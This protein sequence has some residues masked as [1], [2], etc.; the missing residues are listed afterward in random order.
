VHAIIKSA[1]ARRWQVVQPFLIGFAVLVAACTPARQEA[2]IAAPPPPA[3]APVAP[4]LPVAKLNKVALLVP[5]TGPNAALGESIANAAAMAITDLGKP[6]VQ[7]ISF[8]TAGGAG[9]AAA[10][11]LA[12][13][14]G[15]ILGPLLSSEV[16]AV[17]AAVAGRPVP[18]LSFSNDAAAAGSDVFVLGF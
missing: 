4:A 17:Q 2:P 3:T 16:P 13:G 8:D 18:I 9:E 14:A 7:L 15:L 1:P 11:A 10:K 12:A 5:L 6:Q